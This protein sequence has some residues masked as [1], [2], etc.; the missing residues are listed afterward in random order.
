VRVHGLQ[1][2]VLPADRV[3]CGHDRASCPQLQDAGTMPAGAYGPRHG[4]RLRLPDVNVRLHGVFQ[5]APV[6]PNNPA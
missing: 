6:S 4:V 2:H 5:G 1:E 3:S